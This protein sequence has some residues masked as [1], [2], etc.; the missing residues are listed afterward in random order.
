M[1]GIFEQ[2]CSP[3]LRIWTSSPQSE[4]FTV[5]R[6]CEMRSLASIEMRTRQASK[7]RKGEERKKK[8]KE[9]EKGTKR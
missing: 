3:S 8:E 9:K 4:H 5:G 7:E 6:I 2:T 1:A